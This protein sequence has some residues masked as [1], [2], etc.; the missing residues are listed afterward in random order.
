MPPQMKFFMDSKA[1]IGN[2]T[3]CRLN[4]CNSGLESLELGYV[5]KYIT[6]N[7]LNGAHDSMVDVVAQTDIVTHQHFIS[8]LDVSKS[9]RLIENIFTKTERAEMLKK[10]EPSRPVHAPWFEQTA[11][12]NVSW[13]PWSDNNYNGAS[14]GGVFG[15]SGAML[16]LARKGCLRC[17]FLSSRSRCFATLHFER[18][19]TR[20]MNGLCQ[21][22]VKINMVTQQSVQSLLLFFRPADPICHLML[23]S[24]VRRARFILS[25]KI[26]SLP[27]SVF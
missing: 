19:C 21:Q 6:G 16:Q 1:V 27:G 4:P 8:Y 3:G 23:G 25:Q 17:S 5:W 2:Y 24:A 9:V 15:P 20:T 11:E 12:D 13:E 26:S 18:K 10:L 22:H 14:A 7:N